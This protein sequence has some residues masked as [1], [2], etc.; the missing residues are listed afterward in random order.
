M[1]NLED[2][3]IVHV[4]ASSRC[5]SR[6]PMCSRYTGTGF[7]Q[8]GLVEQ[9]LKTDV[10]Y[11]LFTKELTEK[12]DYVYFSGVYG[13]PCLNKHLPDFVQH[14]A[15]Y[16]QGEFGIGIDTNG[17]YRDPEWWAR[18][19]HPKVLI[20]FALDGASRETLGQY[21]IGVNYDKVLANLKSYVAAGGKAAWNFI[22]FKHNEH[23]VDTAR[24]IAEDLGIEFRVKVTQK[25]RF[26]RDFKVMQEGQQ[27]AVLEPPVNETY[28]HTNVGKEEHVPI[29]VFKFDLTRFSSLD[30]NTV[31]CKSLARKEI[32][33]SADGLVF[34]CCYLGTY[35]HDSP[36]AYQFN[37]LYDVNE[38]DLSKYDIRNI[39]EKFNNISDKWNSSVENGNLITCL[40]TCG[41]VENTTLY[42]SKDLNKET[43]LKYA[44]E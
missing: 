20:N 18:L 36:G 26:K 5:N 37:N 41:N 44:K 1:I 25:F 13:D 35:T 31:N 22:V 29:T 6:C 10:F 7:I 19:A 27:I 28:R 15:K 14:L 42:H 39:L 9:D 38:F 23:E 12:L 17:G 43:V 11:K 21:R 34:P 16:G 3:R 8:P 24:K 32:F 40:Q 33:L 4:E 2:I 30:K